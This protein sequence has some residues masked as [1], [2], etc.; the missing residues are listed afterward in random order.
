MA[1]PDLCIFGDSITPNQH[2]IARDYLLM[3]NYYV[4]GKSS[5]EGHHWASA[6]MVTD[7]TEKSVRAWF[8][9]YPHVLYDAMVYD[10]KGLIWNNALDHGKTCGSTVKPVLC[11][12]TKNNTTGAIC[13][14]YGRRT[15]PFRYTNTTTISRVRPIL[16]M[17]FPGCDDE[18]IS[19]QM[20]AD[21]F[22]KELNETA[23]NPN[24]D[25]P[26]LMVMSLP[27][28]HTSGMSPGFP[29]PRAMVADNDLAVGR[30]V[31]AV[32]PQPVCGF[33]GYIYYGR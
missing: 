1:V 6:A 32:T 9:S 17:N 29:T 10:K 16:A 19:D 24:A 21:A 27:N 4:S 13:I 8:R 31:D 18:T 33:H 5:A 20:R 11:V 26:N 15:S 28:D 14:S 3:D 12:T 2:R 7:Y 30:I 25:L 23:A 22:I